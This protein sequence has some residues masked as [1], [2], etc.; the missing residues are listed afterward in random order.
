MCPTGFL[1]KKLKM[2]TWCKLIVIHGRNV[3]YQL[4]NGF[5]MNLTLFTIPTVLI[6]PLQLLVKRMDG[7][8]QIMRNGSGSHLVAPSQGDDEAFFTLLP[9]CFL[10]Y[11]FVLHRQYLIACFLASTFWVNKVFSVRNFRD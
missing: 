7:Q 1:L 10:M 4:E 2:S 3:T 11:A 5:L 8:I 6:S 9:F